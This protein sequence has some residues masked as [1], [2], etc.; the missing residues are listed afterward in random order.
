MNSVK[1][2]YTF[3]TFHHNVKIE[4]ENDWQ[5]IPLYFL[6][7]VLFSSMIVMGLPS[8]LYC[9]VGYLTLIWLDSKRTVTLS[10]QIG[11]AA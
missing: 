11:S 3:C 6:N 4:N 5:D 1:Q 8:L 10:Q 9:G 7:L 2:R